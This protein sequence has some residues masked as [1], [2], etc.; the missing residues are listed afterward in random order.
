[1]L[2]DEI[3]NIASRI[4]RAREAKNNMTVSLET[5]NLVGAWR[6]PDVELINKTVT[7]GNRFYNVFPY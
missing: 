3:T 4:V 7:E 6:V 5:G 1:M 2:K